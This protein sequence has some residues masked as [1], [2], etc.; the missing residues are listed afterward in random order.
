MATRQEAKTPAQRL[1][2]ALGPVDRW[3]DFDEIGHM[4]LPSRAVMEDMIAPVAMAGPTSR[5]GPL[6]K[7]HVF[8]F[9]G[10]SCDGCSVAAT[11]AQA[12][13]VES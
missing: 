11:G 2:E 10:M 7:I 13:S 6:E 9:A 12:P 4:G 5:L 8:W 3:H 1:L